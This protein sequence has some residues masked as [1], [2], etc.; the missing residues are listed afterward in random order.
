M[1]GGVQGDLRSPWWNSVLPLFNIDHGGS[2]GGHKVS[3]QRLGKFVLS[4]TEYFCLEITRVVLIGL[5]SPI[6]VA[7]SPETISENFRV[8]VLFNLINKV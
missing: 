6:S 7:T 8:F 5:L 1:G 3:A 4:V 2:L